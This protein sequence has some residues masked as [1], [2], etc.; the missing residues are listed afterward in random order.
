VKVEDHPVAVYLAGLGP[1]S[2]RTMRVA[3]A[4]IAKVINPEMD[5]TTFPW[6]QL[7]YLHTQAIRSRLMESLAPSTVNKHLAALRGV[8]REALRLG[9]MTQEDF[10]RATDL[11]PA[12]GERLP[13]GR[14]VTAGELRAIFEVCRADKSVA[15][16]RRDA[17]LLGLL[18]GCGL[19]R[20]EAVAIEVADIDVEKSSAAVRKAKGDKQ[21]VVFMPVGTLRAIK[22]WLQVRGE[23][24]GPLVTPVRKGGTVI[25]CSMNGQSVEK[26][27]RR[28]AREAGLQTLSPHDMRRSHISH[29]LEAGADIATVQKMAGHASVTTTSRYDRRGDAT[30]RK[31]ADLL[32]VP[33]E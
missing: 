12:R 14:E 17:A 8:L 11:R 33:C 31:A 1:G 24:P 28:R 9:Q 26:I 10:T 21:R 15:R 29:L 4:N 3:L 7:R 18:Y 16:G 6:A 22:A 23:G 5:E 2:R 32:H 13:A 27:L 25:V 19:R 30:Q 20:S